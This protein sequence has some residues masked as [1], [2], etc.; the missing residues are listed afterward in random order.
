M[1]YPSDKGESLRKEIERLFRVRLGKL[2]DLLER[3]EKQE[4]VTDDKM[5]SAGVCGLGGWSKR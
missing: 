4:G 1:K 2:F 5:D 3:L